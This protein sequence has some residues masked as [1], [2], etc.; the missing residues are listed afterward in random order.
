MKFKVE[1]FDINGY[2]GNILKTKLFRLLDETQK[3]ALVF[4]G[5]AYNSTMPL[6]HYSVQSILV[7][8]INVLTVDYDYSNNS[9]FMKHS[10]RNQSEWLIGDV[11]ASLKFAT[12]KKNQEVVCLAGKSLG[13]LALGHLLETHENL[14]NAKTIW[15]TPLIRNPQLMEQMLSYM[16]DAIMVIGT[17][18]SQYDLDLID[19]LNAN[20]F[21]GGIVVYGANHSLE[22]EGDVTKSLR[23]LMQIVTI[24]QQF[25][26]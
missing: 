16:K 21:L 1:Q 25:L 26:I 14:R 7:T 5:L 9:Q 2:N 20:T 10:L 15:L 19:R 3:I 23:V 8:G 17:S 12:Q 13:T 24:I 11:E 22:I 4:P 18:D 6:L